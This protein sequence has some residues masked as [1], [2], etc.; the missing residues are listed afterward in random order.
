MIDYLNDLIQLK[1][2]YVEPEICE[3][4]LGNNVNVRFT[5]SMLCAGYS[6]ALRGDGCSGDS[7]GPFSMQ[8]AGRYKTFSYVSKLL[9]KKIVHI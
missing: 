7:G 9:C 5:D 4:S 6:R 3:E 2:P 1:V 8:Y